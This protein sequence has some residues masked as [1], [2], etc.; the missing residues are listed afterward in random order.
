M[1]EIMTMGVVTLLT[2]WILTV[3]IMPVFIPVLHKFKFGQSIREDGPQSHL[4]K[5]GTPTMGGIAFVLSTMITMLILRPGFLA[6]PNGLAIT[7]VFLGYFA[8]GLA[9][10]MLIVIKKQNEGLSPKAKLA[11]Q[12]LVTI[13]LVVVYPGRFFDPNYTNITLFYGIS[14]NL[15]YIYILFA[16]IMFV[17][18]SNAINFTDGLDGLSSITVAIALGFMAIIAYDQQQSVVLLYICALI[19]GLLGFYIFNKKPAKI[20]MGDTGSLALGGF[21]AVVALLLKVEI[22]SLIIGMVFVV[23]MASVVIQILYFKKTGKRIFR[24][25]PIHHHFE[26]GTLKE[27]GTVFMMYIFGLLFGLLGMVLYFV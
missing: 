27:Q 5:Q 1:N 15:H 3:I 14:I 19:G 7:I 25:A 8:I 9:D 12:C 13:V 4:K 11:L 6:S 16:L 24:M 2:S 26:M 20:F 17:G 21:Y 18:Y 10:D 23:E 22:L